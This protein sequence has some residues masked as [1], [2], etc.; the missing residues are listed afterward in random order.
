MCNDDQNIDYN[1]FIYY[2]NISMM[3]NEILFRW[4]L[5]DATTIN[6]NVNIERSNNCVKTSKIVSGGT[7][8]PIWMRT[9]SSSSWWSPPQLD[10]RKFVDRASKVFDL[11]FV[12]IKQSNN[13][14]NLKSEKKFVLC[15]IIWPVYIRHNSVST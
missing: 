7:S 13:K 3:F 14:N 1:N 6:M 15:C 2:L 9:S 11:L 4:F 10:T 5:F 8:G 12:S